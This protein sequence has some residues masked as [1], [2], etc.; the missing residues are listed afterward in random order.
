MIS[1]K[2]FIKEHKDV[3]SLANHLKSKY[4]L[5]KLHLSS[6]GHTVDINRIDVKKEHQGKGVGSKVINHVSDWAKKNGHKSVSLVSSLEHS[7]GKIGFY[8]KLG[9]KKMHRGSQLYKKEL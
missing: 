9:F 5:D 7:K 4:P 6:D 1:F 3:E 2:E 8:D